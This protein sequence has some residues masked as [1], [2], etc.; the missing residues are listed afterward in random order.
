MSKRKQGRRP[1]KT[2]VPAAAPRAEPGSRATAWLFAP[3]IL[4]GAL[5]LFA[6][7]PLIARYVLPWFGGG[8][9]VWTTCMLFF[10]VLLLGGSLYAHLSVRLLPTRGQILLHL[11][12]VAGALAMIPIIPA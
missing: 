3:A 8:P 1:A 6:V 5:L 4:T 7:Q 11:L 2:A 9:G 12:L 10:Q